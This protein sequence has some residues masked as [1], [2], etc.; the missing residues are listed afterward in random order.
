MI[1]THNGFQHQTPI[2]K[3]GGLNP[4]WNYTVMPNLNGF[5]QDVKI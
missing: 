5:D 1:L 4:Q 2:V 3:I